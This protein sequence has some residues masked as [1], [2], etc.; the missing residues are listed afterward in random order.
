MRLFYGFVFSTA[1][2]LELL[3][4]AVLL[5][6]IDA[7]EARREIG[8]GSFVQVIRNTAANHDDWGT[9]IRKGSI[10]LRGSLNDIGAPNRGR[11][12]DHDIIRLHCYICD[13]KRIDRKERSSGVDDAGGVAYDD[14]V[15][16]SVSGLGAGDCIGCV[17]CPQN[18]GAVFLPL[19][20]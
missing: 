15:S 19:K 5:H 12:C 16:S 18:I 1:M 10:Y 11:P 13:V 20:T 8:R 14:R 3:N 4:A 17:R 9:D 7:I 6:Q 2:V